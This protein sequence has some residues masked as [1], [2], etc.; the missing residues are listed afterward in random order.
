LRE[1]KDELE[2]A[3]TCE[4]R[5]LFVATVAPPVFPPILLFLHRLLR[6]RTILLRGGPSPTSTLEYLKIK[7]SFGL[8][9]ALQS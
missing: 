7:L 3:R 9:F 4:V 8:S 1:E 2:K 6:P 5:D